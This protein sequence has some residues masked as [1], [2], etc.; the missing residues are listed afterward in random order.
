MLVGLLGDH[1][2]LGVIVETEDPDHA[3]GAWGAAPQAVQ[4]MSGEDAVPGPSHT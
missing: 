1:P 4:E 3:A 2:A